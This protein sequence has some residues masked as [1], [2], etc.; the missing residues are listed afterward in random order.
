MGKL[1][2]F[3]FL[4]Y[5]CYSCATNG[6]ERHSYRVDCLSSGKTERQCER[7]YAANAMAELREASNE[8]DEAL[9]NVT[10]P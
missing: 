7:E 8:L 5:M 6:A 2:L 10:R 9:Y 4:G 1:L 3:G